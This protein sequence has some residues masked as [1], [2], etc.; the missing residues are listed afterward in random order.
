MLMSKRFQFTRLC[1]RC[2]SGCQKNVPVFKRFFLQ[3][4]IPQFRNSEHYYGKRYKTSED[5]Y[6]NFSEGFKTEYM[7]EEYSIQGFENI[8][9]Y[10]KFLEFCQQVDNIEK[11]ELELL[12]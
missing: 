9:D 10:N 7:L 3:Q 8:E 5:R 1:S 12:N 4:L 2:Y 11:E 6:H